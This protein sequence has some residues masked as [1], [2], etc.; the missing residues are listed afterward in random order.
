MD[1]TP[2]PAAF[3]QDQNTVQSSNIQGDFQT[4]PDGDSLTCIMPPDGGDYWPFG[5]NPST[6]P[7]STSTPSSTQSTGTATPSGASS[8][9]TGLSSGAKAGIAV[10]VILGVVAIAALTH[11]V[12]KWAL[13][14]AQA[15]GRY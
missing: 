7:S 9:H 5:G 6:S 11:F 4:V 1:T 10:G 15:T 14:R 13:N 12:R 2:T 8:P 3:V